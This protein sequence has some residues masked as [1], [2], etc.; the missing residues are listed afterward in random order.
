[1]TPLTL[2]TVELAGDRSRPLLLVGPSL[3]TTAEL[4]WA[5][6]AAL[7]A[8]D[9]HVVG[10]DLPGHGRSPAVPASFSIG[11]LADAVAGL[12]GDVVAERPGASF[13]YAGDSVGGAVGLQLALEH[14][15]RLRHVAVLCSGAKLGSPEDWRERAELVR[16]SGTA[17]M[18]ERSSERWFAA[19]FL[20]REPEIGA[21]L[22]DALPSIKAHSY[23]RVCE[24]LAAFDVG[25]RLA[26]IAVPL[27]V[28]GGAQDVAAPD[29]L[30]EDLAR[31]VGDA[32]LAVLADCGHLAPVEQPEEVAQLLRTM[33]RGTSLDDLHANG[34]RVRRVV[35][36]DDHVDR[37]NAMITGFTAD[38]QQLISRYAWG[39][40]WTRP[41]LDRRS[42][43]MITLTALI[44]GGHHDE[45]AMHVR[46]A[47]RNGLTADEIA[48]V[49]LQSA[50]YCGVPAANSAFKIAQ[51]TLASMDEEDR[52]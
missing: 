49:L 28:I 12:A 32:E 17:A 35:L 2:R 20:Q 45:L 24:A 40:I 31:A 4:L 41:G 3:G 47:R 52:G 38:F 18:V 16:I 30:S 33:V 23:A 26:E 36:G 37:A 50:I 19:G 25:D 46:A 14:A 6:C 42:R 11:D 9:F 8:D 21:S 27:L 22:L 39:S 48:E 44:A 7:L 1:M 43:S 13:Y 29:P 34:T 10:W 5:R 15:D 51:E